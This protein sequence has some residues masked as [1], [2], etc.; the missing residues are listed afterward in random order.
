M[1]K[2]KMTYRL[3]LPVL[4]AAVWAC[5]SENEP[6]K[7]E[8]N[9][10]SYS[11][12]VLPDGGV[13]ELELQANREW[14]VS[15]DREWCMV[16][17]LNGKGSTVCEI[18]VDS[19]Y[20]YSEREAHITFRC[21]GKSRQVTV[22]QFGYEKVIIPDVD[23][24]EV[25]DFSDYGQM[26][27]TLNVRSN[28]DYDVL[29][30][31]QDLSRTG[32]LT[33]SKSKPSVQ[34]I[35]RGATVRLDYRL[36]TESDVDRIAKVIF[37]QNDAQPGE[38]PVEKAVTF[39]QKHAQKIV[40]SR[41]G[42]SLALVTISRIMHVAENWDM[43]QPMIYWRNVELADRTYF[44][45]ELQKTVTEPRVVKASFSMFDTNEGI[46]YQIQ[47]MDQ[48][49]E[50]YFTANSNAHLK[51]IDLGESVCKL[52]HLKVLSLVGYGLSRLPAQMKNLTSL[53]ELELSG[54]NFQTLPMDIISALDKHSL[55]Y[56]NFS[57]NRR[58]DVFSHFYENRSV[59]DTLGLHGELPEEIFKLKNIS[60]IGLSY[61][62]FE[63]SIPEMDYS[64]S[65][66]GTLEEKIANNPVMPQ[67]EQ[68]SI[69]LNYLTGTVPD[70]ILYHPNLRCWD[71]YTLV[72]NQFE[73]SRDSNGRK[74][75][76]LN[77]PSSIPQACP[78]WESDFDTTFDKISTF[79][80]EVQYVTLRGGVIT[81]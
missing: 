31:Y 24:I 49:E 51:R 55:W 72:F 53:E 70:W 40:P 62:Y 37:R 23:Y 60:Y 21:G 64:A 42:D 18:S 11:V 22:S 19:S 3:L 5:N 13:F 57:N 4:L 65:D 16:S 50:I 1:N 78:L 39:C 8:L 32:W 66:Y 14:V 52:P 46:P 20:L 74:T 81:R 61:N 28:V 43:S 33:I 44:N 45:Q 59:R 27:K 10:E 17:P 47:F 54:N 25:P 26:F 68:L 34:S 48:L 12:S 2:M 80:Q 15:C 56:I 69:N 30:E 38:T 41:Q 79:N 58:R 71:P 63:G 75:G 7:T 67:L 29:I 9:V 73:Y 77:E 36:Y 76:F 6:E 35:P